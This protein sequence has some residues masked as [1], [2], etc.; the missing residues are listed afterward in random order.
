MRA[1][2]IA[3]IRKTAAAGLMTAALCGMILTGCGRREDEYMDEYLEEY[4]D[5]DDFEDFDEDDFEDYSEE[6]R[7]SE[8][9]QDMG[10]P[11]GEASY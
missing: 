9:F 1:D 6:S 8:D 3:K 5:E 11:V 2:E 10:E 4:L 7:Y